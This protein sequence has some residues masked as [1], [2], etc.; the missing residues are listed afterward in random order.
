MC[1]TPL[2]GT[3]V[4]AIG[5]SP[6][7]P[8]GGVT[9]AAG[10]HGDAVVLDGIDGL[11]RLPSVVGADFTAAFWVRTN[12][13]APGNATSLWFEGLSLVDGEVCATPPGGD[14]G[15]AL[16]DGGHIVGHHVHSL[17]E[18]NDGSWYHA[19]FT[20]RLS[21]DERALFVDGVEQ[22]RGPRGSAG[23]VH[24]AIPFVGLGNNPCRVASGIGPY[25]PGSIDDAF[26]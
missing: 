26:L 5:G 14:W 2:D 17:A 13:I 19:T 10:K 15:T 12:A 25:F 7:I 3:L 24:T 20:R 8:S 9:F 4:D 21:D 1:K 18:H 23:L 11:V 6:G 22:G 16:L